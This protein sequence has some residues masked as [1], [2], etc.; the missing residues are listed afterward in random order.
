MVSLYRGSSINHMVTMMCNEMKQFTLIIQ[1][2]RLL[3]MESTLKRE[4]DGMKMMQGNHLIPLN[5]NMTG[6]KMFIQYK[7]L[8][9]TS[10]EPKLRTQTLQVCLVHTEQNMRA[11]KQT[12]TSVFA[13]VW[14]CRD[15]P[16]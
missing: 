8:S 16:A 14:P 11:G 6:E 15:G 3:D 1:K 5:T 10:L 7:L 12:N 2:K 13:L 4:E 9:G